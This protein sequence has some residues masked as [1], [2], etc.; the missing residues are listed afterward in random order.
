MANTHTT[1]AQKLIF[2]EQGTT[3]FANRSWFDECKEAEELEE[4]E[5]MTVSTERKIF[6]SGSF[7]FSHLIFYFILFGV[8][9][10]N[11]HFNLY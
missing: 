6:F 9:F 4:G 2:E 5:I 10:H 7:F 8:I 11:F 3:D 1:M